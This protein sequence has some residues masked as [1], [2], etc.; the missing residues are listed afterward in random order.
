MFH[1]PCSIFYIRVPRTVTFDTRRASPV[2]LTM[3]GACVGRARAVML[4]N[5]KAVISNRTPET[6]KVVKMLSREFPERTENV[7]F[8]E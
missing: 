1:V 6:A 8:G 7:S 3:S 2:L 5:R 4:S